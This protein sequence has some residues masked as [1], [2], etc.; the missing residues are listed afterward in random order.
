MQRRT[1]V[2]VAISCIAAPLAGEAQQTGKVYRIGFLHPAQANH[3]NREAFREAL[4]N[5][6]YVE[7]QNILI[8]DRISTA[9]KDLSAL[10]ADLVGRKVD[11][12]FTWTT[13][14]LVA[15]RKATGTIPI[16]GISGDPVRMGLVASLPKPG[17]NLT[18][19]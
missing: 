16:V 4:R 2:A 5:H 3:Y 10:L 18:G 15:A 13:P 6:G 7:G 1:F 12:I 17:G 19:L 11:V 14:A 9:P 8:E